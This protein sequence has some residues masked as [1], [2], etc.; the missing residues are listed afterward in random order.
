MTDAAT[1]FR[2]RQKDSG[3]TYQLTLEGWKGIHRVSVYSQRPIESRALQDQSVPTQQDF[4]L[5]VKDLRNAITGNG[6]S[7]VI[8]IAN[9]DER[10]RAFS[11]MRVNAKAHGAPQGFVTLSPGLPAKFVSA[12]A[13]RGHKCA[14]GPHAIVRVNEEAQQRLQDFLGHLSWLSPDI[15]SLV[16]NAI[17]RPSLDRRLDRVETRLFAQTSEE[18]LAAASQSL[19]GR[20]KS[21]MARPVPP[22]LIRVVTALLL[23]ALIV[24]NGF[25]LYR[26]YPKGEAL[27]M[28]ALPGRAK[29]RTADPIVD[30]AKALLEAL[31][32]S[33]DPLL[34]K[35]DDAHFGP[36]RTDDE[37]QK[38]FG[39]RD[40]L[41]GLVKLQML[42]IAP[43]PEETEFLARADALT[44]TKSAYA[45]IPQKDVPP[46]A[47]LFLS[48]AGCRM[49][50]EQSMPFQS[51]DCKNVSDDAFEAGLRNLTTFVKGR[52]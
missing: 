40:A 42:A 4:D 50:Y 20:I 36:L 45:A 46:D 34:R 14:G 8:V 41:W 5:A 13:N 44:L 33:K 2:D 18:A 16:L 51:E 39:G 48:A 12:D 29:L 52:P 3:E 47:K 35:V 9:D 25:V 49:Q 1:F 23:A 7:G 11:V 21:W 38:A 6:G 30:D 24:M 43:S 17:R 31:H 28:N 10:S 22:S 27:T 19:L 15:E 32:N 26:L 37:I